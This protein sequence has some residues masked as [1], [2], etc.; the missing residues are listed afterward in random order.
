MKRLILA[1]ADMYRTRARGTA[2]L[3]IEIGAI[4]MA[5][6]GLWMIWPPLALV[7]GGAGAFL[8]AQGMGGDD[9]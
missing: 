8:L 9:R 7:V 1:A 6:A 4:A 5:G 3:L 2:A